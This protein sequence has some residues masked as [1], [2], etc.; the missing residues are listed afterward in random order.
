[1]ELI[2]EIQVYALTEQYYAIP[3]A[4]I[5]VSYAMSKNVFGF[6]FNPGENLYLNT[7]GV[8]AD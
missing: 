6:E 3:V 5:N 7:M 1:M 4:F 8:Y 2:K